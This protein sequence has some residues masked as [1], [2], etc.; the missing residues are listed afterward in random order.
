MNLGQARVGIRTQSVISAN[1]VTSG[2]ILHLDSGNSGSYPGSGTTWTDLSGN[3]RNATLING[4][5]YSSVDGG[6]IVFYGID[7]GRR[8]NDP[9]RIR[10]RGD[11][12]DHRRG[13]Y[14][15]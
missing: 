4:P 1:L 2:L 15:A 14:D 8:G 3:G 7:D 11:G 10:G 6:K 13:V 12:T 5:V 9:S